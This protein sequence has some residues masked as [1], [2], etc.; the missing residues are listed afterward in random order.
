MI[1]DLFSSLGPGETTV[2]IV[3]LS[4]TAM[5]IA[6][7]IFK[8]SEEFGERTTSDLTTDEFK[9]IVEQAVEEKVAPLQKR[10]ADIEEQRSRQLSSN[11][12][13]S[14]SESSDAQRSDDRG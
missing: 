11:S 8:E 6:R 2:L 5:T 10:L 3:F 9:Q 12:R 7:Y 1:F 14:L 13:K 4:I